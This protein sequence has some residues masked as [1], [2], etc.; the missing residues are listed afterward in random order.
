MTTESMRNASISS[1][2]SRTSSGTPNMNN[3]G[4]HH[5]NK[6]SS[7]NLEFLAPINFDDFHNSILD[8]PSLNNF[9]LPGHGGAGYES[10]K[11]QIRSN[12][13]WSTTESI[14]TRTA[15][16]NS[17]RRQN[18]LTRF[19]TQTSSINTSMPPPPA[20]SARSR[21]QSHVPPPY[22]IALQEN[23]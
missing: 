1:T 17:L 4:K 6:S 8:E 2:N 9:P 19:Q 14:T 11:A 15:R 23:Q 22:R 20:P 21:R 12:N 7:E 18:D 13:P 5:S 16:S 3:S 10:K